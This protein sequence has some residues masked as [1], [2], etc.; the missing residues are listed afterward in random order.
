[1]IGKDE[2]CLNCL[3]YKE[4][5]LW[6]SKYGVEPYYEKI[7]HCCTVYSNSGTIYQLQEKDADGLCELFTPKADKITNN[8]D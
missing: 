2:K 3:Y 7:S 5:I 6:D 1:M 4:L 8:D